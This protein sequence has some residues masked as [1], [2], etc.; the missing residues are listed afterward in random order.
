MSEI[1]RKTPQIERSL[2]D[3]RKIYPVRR[4][5]TLDGLTLVSG[6]SGNVNRWKRPGRI[7]LAELA[8][9]KNVTLNKNDKCHFCSEAHL[10]IS[11]DPRTHLRA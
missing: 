11:A 2:P 5:R 6:V 4:S 9:H 1:A 10:R 8:R 3:H 7:Y